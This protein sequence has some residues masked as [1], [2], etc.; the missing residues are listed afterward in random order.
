MKLI[1][2]EMLLCQGERL[3]FDVL[4]SLFRGRFDDARLSG[5][6]LEDSFPQVRLQCLI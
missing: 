3:H 6:Y 5:L 4:I 1:I 2:E